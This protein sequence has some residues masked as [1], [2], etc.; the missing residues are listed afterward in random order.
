[1]ERLDDDQK[2]AGPGPVES[3]FRNQQRSKVFAGLLVVAAGC[4]FLAREAGVFIPEWILTWQMLLIVCG[5]FVGIKHSF[6]NPGWLIMVCVGGVFMVSEFLP[7]YNISHYLWPLAIILVGLFMIFRPARPCRGRYRNRWNRHAYGDFQGPGAATGAPETT[8]TGEDFIQ[9]DSVFASI[10]KNIVSKNFKG[11]E[12]N[13]VFAGAEINL[14]QADIQGTVQLELNA[15][16]GGARIIIPPHW[17][18]KSELTAVL[19]NVEDKRP[20]YKDRPSDGTK[21]LIL[22]G[23][24]VFGG[25]EIQSY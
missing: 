15:V 8:A 13:C 4:L 11:G 2:A 20:V 7:D 22:K 3:H 10:K 19:G 5:I 24:A 14:S 9:Y 18:L 12:I 1:M 21:V 25:I 17:E 23:A 16:F 6:Q